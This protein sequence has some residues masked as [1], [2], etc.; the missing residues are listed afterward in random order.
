MKS[1][2]RILS[3]SALI[4]VGLIAAAY[5]A[6]PSRQQTISFPASGIGDNLPQHAAEDATAI[7]APVLVANPASDRVTISWQPVLGAA[8]YEIWGRQGEETWARLDDDSLTSTS[9]SYTHT[10]LA[11]GE[12]Y[13]YT[14]RTVPTSGAKSAW[15][16]Q[17]QAT[18]T[19]I[20][21]LTANGAIDQ[22][23]LN[24]TSVTDA[25]GYHLIMWKEGLEDWI[26]IG[27]PLTSTVTTYTHSNLSDERT[28][29]Y[30]VRAVVDSTEGE[31]SD[32]VSD[33]PTRPS[34]PT[35]STTAGTGQVQVSWSSIS[36]AD[37]Y[38]LVF[39]TDGHD[40]WERIG[41]PL[42]STAT[43]YTH[44]GL[45]AGQPYYYRASAVINGVEGA[46]S[47]AVSDTP[48]RPASPALSATAATGQIGLS[49]TA[50]SDAD[51]YQLI[52]WTEAQDAWIR[53]GDPLTST[54][55]SYTHSGISSGRTHYYRVRA[56][57]N[58]TTGAWSNTISSVPGT[59]Y[60]P[61]LVA[62]AGTGEVELTWN[63]VSGADSYHIIMWT[64][65]QTEWER[66]GGNIA[67]DK[68]SHTHSGLTAGNTYYYRIRAVIDGAEGLWTEKVSSVPLE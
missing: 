9:T 32:T 34:A 61:G 29:H 52:V 12:T 6:L 63:E 21:T 35:L 50:V 39:W 40:V 27:D 59:S 33:V 24:W 53:T 13:L 51:T 58:G 49:W 55:T 2:L 22:I 20:P 4:L 31:W 26:R 42:S 36:D 30:R 1:M 19:N 28:Y 17:V 44:S 10:G 23:D 66:I 11:S 5:F 47:E 48:G 67:S 25:G 64:T 41:D 15:A 3:L 18:V 14:G 65:G 56:A 16:Q 60:I 8:S 46:W 43:S 62:N 45:I 7:A 54:T 68:T 37:S 57:V 38:R